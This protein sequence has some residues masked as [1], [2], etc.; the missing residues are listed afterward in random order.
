MFWRRQDLTRHS[1][2]VQGHFVE[3]P[4][5]IQY[6]YT[7]RFDVLIHRK[8]QL[9]PSSL[10]TNQMLITDLTRIS[11]LALIAL[12]RFYP[13]V[14][15]MIIRQPL[16]LHYRNGFHSLNERTVATINNLLTSRYK[17][18]FFLTFLFPN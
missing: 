11:Y 13:F 3:A 5:T 17:E 10:Q 1:L 15:S 12:L 4:I 8:H 18:L 16:F 9:K 2:V 7:L 14:D 6:S